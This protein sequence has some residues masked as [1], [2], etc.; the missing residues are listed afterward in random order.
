MMNLILNIVIGLYKLNKE[1][2]IV[3]IISLCPFKLT[4]ALVH[5][6]QLTVPFRLKDSYSYQIQHFNK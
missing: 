2:N 4:Q 6:V 3:I 5:P 1:V